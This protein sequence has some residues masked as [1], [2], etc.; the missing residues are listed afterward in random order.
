M[1][2]AFDGAGGGVYPPMPLYTDVHRNVDADGA[3]VAEA[4][5]RDREVQDRQRVTYPRYWID[6]AEGVTFCRFEA[7][8]VAA[9]EADHLEANDCIADETYGI[10]EGEKSLFPSDYDHR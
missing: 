9:G 2:P 4:V 8:S 5:A 1:W 3:S 6:E 10:K 7:P